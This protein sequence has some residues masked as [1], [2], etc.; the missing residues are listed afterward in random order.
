MRVYRNRQ[1]MSSKIFHNPPV[2]V[3]GDVAPGEQ[4]GDGDDGEAVPE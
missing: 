2:A 4:P 3:D 1:E